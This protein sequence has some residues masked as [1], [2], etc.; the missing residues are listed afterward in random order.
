MCALYILKTY[1]PQSFLIPL[2][3]FLFSGETGDC[4]PESTPE[5]SGDWSDGKHSSSFSECSATGKKNNEEGNHCRNLRG[6][7][8]SRVSVFPAMDQNNM[9]ICCY[10]LNHTYGR[11]FC[12]ENWPSHIEIFHTC[13]NKPLFVQHYTFYVHQTNSLKFPVRSSISDHNIKAPTHTYSHC[14][15]ITFLATSTA[16]TMTGLLMGP[17]GHRLCV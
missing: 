1:F 3:P 17:I 8:G 11:L 10:K 14:A 13:N 7:L 2:W 9:N 5:D 4:C 6:A 16:G 15:G 12:L